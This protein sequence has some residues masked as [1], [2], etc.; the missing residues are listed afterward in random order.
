MRLAQGKGKGT[1][2]D[3]RTQQ[4]VLFLGIAAALYTLVTVGIEIARRATLQYRATHPASMG[5]VAEI[6]PHR[7]D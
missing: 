3:D 6:V 2:M 4:F 1:A 5:A 7:H